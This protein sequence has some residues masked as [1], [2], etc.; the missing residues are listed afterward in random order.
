MIRSMHVCDGCGS[1]WAA[2]LT[3]CG[4]C[5]G[6]VRAYGTDPGDLANVVQ[7]RQFPMHRVVSVVAT[8]AALPTVA[9][10]TAAAV[11]TRGSTVE[12][13]RS[14]VSS[15]GGDPAQVAGATKN[16]LRVLARSLATTRG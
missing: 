14:Y 3:R 12:E 8:P 10:P 16:Q 9:T 2:P 5:R 11:P 7:L 1:V 6:T 15:L 13:W 4:R